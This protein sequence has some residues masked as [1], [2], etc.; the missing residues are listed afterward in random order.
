LVK[1]FEG[2]N[3]WALIL[4]GSE[5]LGL[6]SAKKLARHGMNICIV[7]RDR[8]DDI[9]EIQKNFDQII[10]ERVEFISYN[11]DAV[12]P[13]SRSKVISELSKKT[14]SEGKV[15]ILLHSIARG[16]LKAMTDDKNEILRNADFKLTIEYMAVSLY[17]WV[18]DLFQMRLFAPD[19]RVISFT[20]EGSSK[21]WKYYGAVSAA[22]SA[23]EAITRNIALEFAQFGIRANCIQAGIT[24]TKSFRMIPGNEQLAK[25]ARIRNPFKKLTTPE[26]IANAVY[27]LS[28]DE[29]SWING[30]VIPVNGGEHLS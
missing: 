4:G 16:N 8:R 26:D 10:K 24:D 3:Y 12:N 23:L 30:A 27:L 7:H 20:S 22:K 17:D 9:P 13:E 2:K 29:A 6:A 18:Q 25:Y 1:E 11:S 21:A 5:G 15:R 28:L 14:G 19:A